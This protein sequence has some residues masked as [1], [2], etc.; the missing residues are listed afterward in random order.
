MNSELHEAAAHGFSS[1]AASY[2]EGRP[3]YPSAA[4]A[5]LARELRLGT[6]SAV[7]DLAAGTGKLTALLVGTG[8]TVVAVEPVAEMRAILERALPGVRAL[9]GTAEAIPLEA[10]SVDAVTVGQAFH[11]FRGDEALEE[12]HRV[13][14]PGGG[15]ALLWNDRDTSVGWVGRLTELMELHRGDAPGYRSGA[16]RAAFERTT[17]FGPLAH[18]E[19]RHVHRMPPEGVVARVASV[20]FVALLPEP[21]RERLLGEVRELLATD[22]ETRGRSEVELPYRT[23]V[24]WT[25]H[26]A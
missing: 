18:A 15:L 16:W 6:R 8:A 9:P 20:S 17:L 4:G 12:I 19:Y 7:L 3:T 24:Y 13:L 10:G 5:M 21:E 1:A 22:P 11:W 14:R 26:G 2:E 25:R 23:D